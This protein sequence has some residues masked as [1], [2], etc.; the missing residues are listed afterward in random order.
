MYVCMYVCTNIYKYVYLC[1]YVYF[2]GFFPYGDLP[3]PTGVITS[4]T[5]TKIGESTF[6]GNLYVSIHTNK[7]IQINMHLYMYKC[8]H[9]LVYILI[10]MYICIHTYTGM[11]TS[12]TATDLLKSTSTGNK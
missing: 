2:Y 1:I 5:A 6:T 7:Y 11:I 4:A 10:H 9:F 3:K 12:A 8:V